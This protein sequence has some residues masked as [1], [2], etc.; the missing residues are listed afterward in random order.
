M[1]ARAMPKCG[2]EWEAIAILLGQSDDVS[3]VEWQ[4]AMLEKEREYNETGSVGVQRLAS[5]LTT[6]TRNVSDGAFATTVQ[7]SWGGSGFQSM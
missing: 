6:R 7:Q 5:M 4:A 1:K 3:Y 2:P